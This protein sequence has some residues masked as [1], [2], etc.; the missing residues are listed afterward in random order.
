MP[1]WNVYKFCIFI[2]YGR[3]FRR[4]GFKQDKEWQIAALHSRKFKIIHFAP[5]IAAIR[6]IREIPRNPSGGHVF[7]KIF[8]N[9]DRLYYKFNILE[10]ITKAKR[11]AIIYK[12]LFPWKLASSL[13]ESVLVTL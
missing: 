8:K 5:Y 10:V 9:N 1:F 7:I 12:N 11:E 13:H 4:F 6:S 3:L 2:I